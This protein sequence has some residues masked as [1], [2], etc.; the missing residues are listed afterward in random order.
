M[1]IY[2]FSIDNFESKEIQTILFSPNPKG[3]E[4]IIPEIEFRLGKIEFKSDI[5][6]NIFK[7]SIFYKEWNKIFSNIFNYKKYSSFVKKNDTI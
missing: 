6:K 1:T 5:N 4:G 7:T 2:S 3:T